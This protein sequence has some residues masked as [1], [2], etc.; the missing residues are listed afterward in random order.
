[1]T[2]STQADKS[3]YL[4]RKWGLVDDFSAGPKA[5][6]ALT[7]ADAIFCICAPCCDGMTI[8]QHEKILQHHKINL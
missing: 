2:A 7:Q 8:T 6:C 1:M 5:F 4:L 3:A